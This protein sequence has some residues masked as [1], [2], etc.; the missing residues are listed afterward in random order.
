MREYEL[1]YIVRPDLDEEALQAAIGS[2]ERLVDGLGGEVVSTTSWGRRRLAY[3]V[4]HLRDGQYMLLR[5]R[6]EPERVA[7]L[8]RALAIHDTVFRHLLVVDEGPHE[9]P[10]A[11]DGDVAATPEEGPDDA[12]LGRRQAAVAAPA[13][14][15]DEDDESVEQPA[16]AAATE[17]D[18]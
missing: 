2:V 4:R 3:E 9:E 13:Q 18:I 10:A 8:E 1:M 7:P 12:D 16:L 17:E 15:E 6:L 5:L 14:G 11:Q